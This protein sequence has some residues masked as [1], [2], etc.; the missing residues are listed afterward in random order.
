MNEK[1]ICTDFIQLDSTLPTSS[2]IASQKENHEMVYDI[3]QNVAWDN[4]VYD[5][6][7]R[8]LVSAA[9]YFVFGSLAA[10]SAQTRDTLF[11]LLDVAKTKVLDINLR[12]PYFDQPLVETL[13]SRADIVKLNLAELEMISGWYTDF[14]NEEDAI[15]RLQDRFDIHTMIVTKG[16]EGA[17]L[18]VHHTLYSHE[19]YH[20][21]VA[22]T[23]GSGDSFLAGVIFQFIDKIPHEHILDFSNK[24]GAFITTQK[25]A[26]P[27]YQ[28]NEVTT[29]S[30]MTKTATG[31]VILQIHGLHFIYRAKQ[32]HGTCVHFFASIAFAQACAF[33]K[34]PPVFGDKQSV[35]G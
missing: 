32:I 24:L 14:D 5:H 13:L 16:A 22:D 26:C 35:F 10:R 12:A 19:G 4:I 27:L 29:S 23:V 20:V 17:L 9:D 1:Q 25:G 21:T 3:V 31:K 11:Q 7:L 18:K 6:S 34:L 8:D 28:L 33:H 2:V 30:F 15:S